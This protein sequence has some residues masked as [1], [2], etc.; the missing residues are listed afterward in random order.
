MSR[1]IFPGV[2][3]TAGLG[4]LVLAGNGRADESGWFSLHPSGACEQCCAALHMPF[5]WH[6]RCPP[7]CD[8]TFGYYPTV[9]RAWPTIYC[10]APEAFPLTTA[11]GGTGAPAATP[12]G[13]TPRVMPPASDSDARRRPAGPGVYPTAARPFVSGASGR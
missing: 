8:P 7:Y 11:P 9:W 2:L 3:L 6:R 10:E 4:L 1:S 13:E 12:P 5:F